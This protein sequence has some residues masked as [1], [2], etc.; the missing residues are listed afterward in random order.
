MSPN[1]EPGDTV[2]PP[3]CDDAHQA[4]LVR[5]D[6]TGVEVKWRAHDRCQPDEWAASWIEAY[7]SRLPL[8]ELNGQ[9]GFFALALRRCPNRGDPANGRVESDSPVLRVG[10]GV[11]EATSTTAAL[12]T[13]LRQAKTALL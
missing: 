10:Y 12:T 13:L 11:D 1:L 9:E 5:A 4:L 6:E 8:A 2:W 7:Q 3:W